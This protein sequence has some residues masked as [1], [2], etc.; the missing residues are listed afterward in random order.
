MFQDHDTTYLQ[1]AVTSSW[2]RHI[3]R[4]Q[5]DVIKDVSQLRR[6][7]FR[8]YW[9]IVTRW[10]MT[11]V[12][13]KRSQIVNTKTKIELLWDLWQIRNIEITSPHR[14]KYYRYFYIAWRR[15]T[16]AT[17]HLALRINVSHQKLFLKLLY[18]TILRHE[19]CHRVIALS[20]VSR[21]RCH[22]IIMIRRN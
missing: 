12:H 16:T 7:I 21:R 4:H 14:I 3:L 20:A 2:W 11:Y 1:L 18:I 5:S 17:A 22:L 13:K 9:I 15:V 8:I 19:K 10:L 6:I